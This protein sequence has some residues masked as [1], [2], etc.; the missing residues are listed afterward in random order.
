MI[1]DLLF[2]IKIVQSIFEI[3]YRKA[4]IPIKERHILILYLQFF[5]LFD[6]DLFY[7]R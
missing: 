1:D 3:D 5:W 6:F 2:F 4:N 7:V